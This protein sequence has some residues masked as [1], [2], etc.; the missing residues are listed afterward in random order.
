MR[1]VVSVFCALGGFALVAVLLTLY[2]WVPRW[3]ASLAGYGTTLS[4]SEVL[5]IQ[6]SDL[7][8][9]YSYIVLPIVLIPCY[10]LGRFVFSEGGQSSDNAT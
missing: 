2:F 5:V 7:L 10:F 6:L 1:I 3:K 8:V 9:T 4:S